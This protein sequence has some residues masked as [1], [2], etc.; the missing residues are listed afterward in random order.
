MYDY[1]SYSV[2][3]ATR[4]L[5]QHVVQVDLVLVNPTVSE[6]THN[7]AKRRTIKRIDEKSNLI[8]L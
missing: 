3:N 7:A 2:F 8:K 5:W 1:V 4:A 6:I